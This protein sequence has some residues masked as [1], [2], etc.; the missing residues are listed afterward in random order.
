[1][2]PES[3]KNSD[4]RLYKSI[5]FPLKWEFE[6]QLMVDV[7]AADTMLFK[8]DN[9]WF[10]M[11][12]ICSAKISDHQSELHIFY[13]EDFKNGKWLPIDS[14]NPVIFDP[15]KGRNGGFFLHDGK[16]Y[17]VN[18][19]HGQSHYGKSFN[20]NEI[21]VLSKEKY[22]ETEVSLVQPNFKDTSISTHHFN[23][24][25]SVAVVDFARRERLRKALKS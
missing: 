8:I 24:N 2:I 23:A 13:S 1:M 3:S 19:V 20:V 14:G 11:T 15:L 10:M 9:M 16:L 22:S 7:D 17:R 6:K 18:Q 12:N 4:I 5:N 21:D 25:A